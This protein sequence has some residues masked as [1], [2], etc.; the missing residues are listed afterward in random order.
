MR[1]E[2]GRGPYD[3]DDD[4]NEDWTRQQRGSNM[5]N[6]C[7]CRLSFDGSLSERGH[8]LKIRTLA[9]L[10]ESA[11]LEEGRHL[12]DKSLEWIK[13]FTYEIKGAF[14]PQND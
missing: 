2:N 11:K 7:N 13:L 8:V 4:N 9:P 14:K 5:T 12:S 6:S 1:G 3:D 10:K